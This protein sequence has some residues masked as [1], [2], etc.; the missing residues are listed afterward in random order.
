MIEPFLRQ[1]PQ[2]TI[3][4]L[5]KLLTQLCSFKNV[6]K[7]GS[8]FIEVKFA[9]QIEP[10]DFAFDGNPYGS[11]LPNFLFFNLD[12]LTRFQQ[13]AHNRN[14]PS[15]QAI[16]IRPVFA[17]CPTSIR[18]QIYRQRPQPNLLSI[19]VTTVTNF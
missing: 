1:H 12:I 6:G 8:R 7:L 10:I 19:Q 9:F 4:Q 15:G 13:L 2:R 5:H 14:H 18:T 16:H 17:P 3:A 11:A